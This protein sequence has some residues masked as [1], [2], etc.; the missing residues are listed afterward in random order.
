MPDDNNKNKFKSSTSSCCQQSLN[1]I[2]I[3]LIMWR[4]F[5]PLSMFLVCMLCIL[6]I[7][8]LISKKTGFLLIKHFL[9]FP[10]LFFLLLVVEDPPQC[11]ADLP[12]TRCFDENINRLDQYCAA[13]SIKGQEDG[14][15]AYKNLKLVFLALAIRHGD[16][17]PI[18][19][20][21]GS[22]ISI[23]DSKKLL[24]DDE[25]SQHSPR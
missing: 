5:R 18:H 10:K 24:L 1:N 3:Q 22:N 13:M 8:V 14:S 20:L 17:S 19:S 25:A 15:D 4:Q 21:P 9:A 11:H 16:R 6:A 23:F 2:R 7:F 12:K